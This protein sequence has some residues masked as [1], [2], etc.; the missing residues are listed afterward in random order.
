MVV[1]FACF[2]CLRI[3]LAPSD[4]WIMCILFCFVLQLTLRCLDED[5]ACDDKNAG[6]DDEN[7]V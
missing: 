1:L 7:S 6:C 3:S 5:A 4:T 2:I